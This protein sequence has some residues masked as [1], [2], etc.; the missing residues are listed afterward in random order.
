MSR[1]NILF[2]LSG[3]IAAYKACEV[4][5]TLVQNDFAV[6]TA[7]TPGALRFVGAAT[8]EGLSQYPVFSDLYQSGRQ[9]DHIALARW[10]DLA[11]LC[12]AS[13][14]CLNRLAAGIADDPVGALFL[15]HEFDAKPYLMAPAM[16]QQM[17]KHPTVKESLRRVAT[18][19]VRV[20][21]SGEG[22]LACGE[23]GIG[24]LAEPAQVYEEILSSLKAV[25][26]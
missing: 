26:R 20:L 17:M 21:H 14:S 11:I 1:A 4:I 12:P 23:V 18:F 24:R 10:A 6:R 8:L 9:M 7:V 2:N 22:M 19:G 3:S 16:N 13:A 25:N 5:S 15:A